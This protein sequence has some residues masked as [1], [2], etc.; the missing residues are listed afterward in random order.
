MAQAL[1]HEACR[2]GYDVL[3]ISA[4]RLLAHL[5]GGRAD[6]TYDRRLAT[7]LRPDLLIIDDFG[8]KPLLP[9]GPEDLYEI[10]NER[11]ERGSLRSSRRTAPSPNGRTSFTVRS[12]P[13][14]RS[15]GS[16]TMPI[17]S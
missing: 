7:Y 1:G 12:S 4:S 9:P 6:G 5:H 8:L 13:R 15:I 14:P 3:F 2:R 11:Y 10:V 17:N 16:P